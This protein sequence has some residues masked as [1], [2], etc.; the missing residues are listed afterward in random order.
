[1]NTF[2]NRV[3]TDKEKS[4]LSN[5]VA[6][7]FTAYNFFKLYKKLIDRIQSNACLVSQYINANQIELSEWSFGGNHSCFHC[8]NYVNSVTSFSYFQPFCFEL[9]IHLIL[10]QYQTLQKDDNIST[11][12][13]QIIYSSAD[14]HRQKGAIFLTY[15]TLKSKINLIYSMLDEGTSNDNFDPEYIFINTLNYK[16]FLETTE[17]YFNDWE[18]LKIDNEFKEVNFINIPISLGCFLDFILS[19][20]PCDIY[21]ISHLSLQN[22][23]IIFL[24][25]LNQ[26]KAY[27]ERKQFIV[28][29]MNNFC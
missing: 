23:N 27:N 2:Y 8:N 18:F 7:G 5:Q 13:K 3:L 16:K 21:R 17:K 14:S 22:N 12:L 28:L 15:L 11:R 6:T 10:D 1:M 26:I 20:S 9:T 25:F 24:D 19:K 4:K 29:F